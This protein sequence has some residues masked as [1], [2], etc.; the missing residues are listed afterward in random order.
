MKVWLLFLSVPTVLY[1]LSW[2]VQRSELRRESRSVVFFCMYAT[3][4]AMIIA[5]FVYEPISPDFVPLWPLVT[6]C[7]L[8]FATSFRFSKEFWEKPDR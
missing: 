3:A 6:S 4:L 5:L 1:F 7:L 8:M 2:L